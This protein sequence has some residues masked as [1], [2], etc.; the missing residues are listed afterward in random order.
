MIISK[1]N[2]EEDYNKVKREFQTKNNLLLAKEIAKG[3]KEHEETIREVFGFLISAFK[4][5]L[6]NDQKTP[7]VF[8]SIYLTKLLY[9]CGEKDLNSLLTVAL[10]DVLEDTDIS[11]SMLLNQKFMMKKEGIIINLRILKEDKN[12]SREPDGETLPPRY[13][14]HIKRIIGAPKEVINTEIIDRFSDLMDLEYITKLP[15]KERKFRLAAKLIKVKS[16]VENITRDRSDFNRNCLKLFDLKVKNIEEQENI[17]VK[18]QKI[19][20]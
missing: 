19:I 3:I 16:F 12:L 13:V 15:E 20:K 11:E 10:H 1:E 6:R 18:S 2:I 17:K 8:H 5:K 7:L 4:G 14:E 9:L